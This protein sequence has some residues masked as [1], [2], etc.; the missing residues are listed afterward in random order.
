MEPPVIICNDE[1]RFM[2]AEQ[3]RKIN[4]DPSLIILEPVGRNTSAAIAVASL[5]VK[6]KYDD[7]VLLVFIDYSFLGFII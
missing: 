7:P 4:I 1:Y 5:M 3:M 2:I 6:E